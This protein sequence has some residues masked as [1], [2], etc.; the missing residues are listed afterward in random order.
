MKVYLAFYIIKGT[1]HDTKHLRQWKL[2][3]FTMKQS[4]QFGRIN[5][6]VQHL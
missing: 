3:G 1:R 6:Y 4:F 5:G 2:N